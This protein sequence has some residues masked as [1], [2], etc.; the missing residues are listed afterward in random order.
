MVAPY[1]AMMPARAE[2]TE[3]PL[4][5]H[6]SAS[7]AHGVLADPLGLLNDHA[8][9]EKKAAGNALELLN[10][11]PGHEDAGPDE[12]DLRTQWAA[13]MTA[14]AK[15][16][17]D[18]L[19]LVL[20]LLIRRGGRFTKSHRNPY[21]AALRQLVRGGQGPRELLDR[22]LISALIEAR[23]CERFELL[24]AHSDDRELSR[25]YRGLSNSERGHYVVFLDLA[26]RLPGLAEQADARWEQMLDAEAEIIARQPA[27]A[28]MHSGEG[29]GA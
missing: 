19:G 15:D 26:R 13:T 11:W 6:T 25:L 24:A 14:V 5:Y 22:L 18:H 20:K 3:L 29:S 23:S 9:L 12:K 7:W 21:A 1:N 17:A 16:E 2:V 10:R 28:G 27:Y 8:H 4:R